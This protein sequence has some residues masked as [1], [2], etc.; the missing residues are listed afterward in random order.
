M[1]DLLES[2][3]VLHEAGLHVSDRA[4]HKHSYYLIRH[5]DLRGYTDEEIL[6][7]AN[8]ARY[9]RKAPPAPS[10]DNFA[11]LTHTQQQDVEKLAAILRIAE[12]LDRGHR[13]SVRDVAVR[14][15]REQA[16][17]TVRTR[18]DSSVEIASARKRAKYFAD[19]FE[20]EVR[21][22]AM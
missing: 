16:T 14:V 20:V 9:Y 8:T 17:F 6:I 13:R 7:I 22:E 2:A 19:L 18:S 12:A 4:H 5:A 1:T 21:F 3:A 15:T 10:H 11:E